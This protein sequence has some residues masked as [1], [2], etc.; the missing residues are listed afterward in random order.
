MSEYDE[1]DNNYYSD[2][3]YRSDEGGCCN[4]HCGCSMPV[5]NSDRWYT[6]KTFSDQTKRILGLY[7]RF[8][9][10]FPNYVIDGHND[11]SYFGNMSAK[12]FNECI[13][14]KKDYDVRYDLTR[15]SYTF[16]LKMQQKLFRKHCYI[17]MNN[18]DPYYHDKLVIGCGHRPIE[19]NMIDPRWKRYSEQHDHKRCYTIDPDLCKNPDTVGVYGEQVFG[20]I[21]DGSFKTISTEGVRLK[22]TPLFLQETK[23]LLSEG[24]KFY[25]DDYFI[26]EK[27]NRKIVF[28]SCTCD[29]CRTKGLYLGLPNMFDWNC[30]QNNYGSEE[31][32]VKKGERKV[33]PKCCHPDI[34]SLPKDKNYDEDE[35]DTLFMKVNMNE[36]EIIYKDFSSHNYLIGKTKY[37]FTLLSNGE[38]ILKFQYVPQSKNY[39]PSDEKLLCGHNVPIQQHYLLMGNIQ[40]MFTAEGNV[41]KHAC[42]Q[43]FPQK[44]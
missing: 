11:V 9:Q 7:H 42:F 25:V 3:D 23:R 38:K 29:Q 16:P 27:K 13:N 31:N 35:M 30:V 6:T 43:Y 20:H 40:V 33:L 2:N 10:M 12:E 5:L 4:Y 19:N 24:G 18:Y 8:N 22:P 32:K 26:F 36:F 21:P 41:L 34:V 1:Y 17:V 15:L 14:G 39:L 37:Y 44:Q 28:N